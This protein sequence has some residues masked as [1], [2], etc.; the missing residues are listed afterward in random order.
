METTIVYW[1]YIGIIVKKME[2]NLGKC[3]FGDIVS[4]NKT[5]GLFTSVLHQYGLGCTGVQTMT[6]IRHIL[7]WLFGKFSRALLGPSWSP[8]VVW[9]LRIASGL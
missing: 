7:S 6:I 3:E 9:P 1:G 4:K 2:T 8:Q 5:N